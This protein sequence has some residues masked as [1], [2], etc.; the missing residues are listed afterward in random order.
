MG[1]ERIWVA[2][3]GVVVAS[4]WISALVVDLFGLRLVGDDPVL[5]LAADGPGLGA[6]AVTA[7][8]LGEVSDRVQ[9]SSQSDYGIKITGTRLDVDNNIGEWD[10]EL[11]NESAASATFSVVATSS[12][13][14][15]LTE[16]TNSCT[17][18]T[19]GWDCDVAANTNSTITF[20]SSLWYLCN[21]NIFLNVS[22]TVAGQSVPSEKSREKIRHGTFNCPEIRINNDLKYEVSES[23]V[24]WTVS[25]DRRYL[26]YNKGITITFQES[27][28][29]TG[30]PSQ[31]TATGSVL[32]CKISKFNNSKETFTAKRA[33]GQTCTGR[34]VNISATAK[35]NYDNANIFVLPDIGRDVWV[36]AVDP[37]VSRV[38]IV[39]STL[40]AVVGSTNQLSLTAYDNDDE[41]HENLP[42]GAVSSWSAT[43]GTISA[44]NGGAGATYTAPASVGNGADQI[45]LTLKYAGNTFIA[46][47]SVAVLPTPEPT[48]T[49]TDTPTHTPTPTDTPTP[50][51]TPTH[52]PTNTPTP[53]D[54]PTHT[55]TPTIRLLQRIRLP[56][57]RR[58]HSHHLQLQPTPLLIPLLTL[59]RTRPR[60][61]IHLLTHQLLL[62][63][64]H[65][66]TRPLQ[67]IR[68]LQ[69]ILLLIHRRLHSHRLQPTPLL[70][71]TRPLILLLQPIRPLIPLQTRRVRHRRI[72]R[73]TPLQTRQLQL[74]LPRIRRH[75]P[76][77]LRIHRRRLSRRHLHPLQP[78]SQSQF[79]SIGWSKLT[80]RRV[81]NSN[82][83]WTGREKV[84]CL[85]MK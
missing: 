39:P 2:V 12:T 83:P 48:P 54:T 58:R 24:S 70:R 29:F 76:I 62:R 75:L 16:N 17:V 60:L 40:S 37:C 59:P 7:L 31:C 67:P 3:L 64:I 72:H 47:L 65:R 5:A 61:P 32:N 13:G 45:N 25:V 53:T 46:T 74:I 63:P 57:H 66:L 71:L 80:T 21:P 10:V 35:F 49:P 82:G 56:I 79:S 20:E 38:E 81:R 6:L 50:T 8:P 52:T 77:P 41:A 4:L 22:A 51:N 18:T 55:P 68:L 15:F 44:T 30:L 42:S 19:S 33:I 84:R 78:R 73:L 36:P 9:G 23:A 14:T 27:T 43:R 69:L 34:N 11:S 28:T 26:Y 85:V 1:V